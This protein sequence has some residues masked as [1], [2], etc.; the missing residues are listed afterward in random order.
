MLYGK[1]SSSFLEFSDYSRD[2]QVK[3]MK[4][5][6]FAEENE[7]STKEDDHVVKVKKKKISK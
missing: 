7:Q 5:R 6:K 3:R 4:L 1:C 2:I